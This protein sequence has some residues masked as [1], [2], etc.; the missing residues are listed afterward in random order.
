[1][2]SIAPL[3][4]MGAFG[5]SGMGWWLRTGALTMFVTGGFT[6]AALAQQDARA[7]VA[8]G[9]GAEAFAEAHPDDTLFGTGW[10]TRTSAFH[11]VC[12]H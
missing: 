12:T 6:L 5:L 7:F 9:Q 1:L 10:V 8:N 3:A 2:I 4:I 11:R